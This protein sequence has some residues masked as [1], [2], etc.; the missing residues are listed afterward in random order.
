MAIKE[1]YCLLWK[2]RGDLGQRLTIEMIVGF[3]LSLEG[4]PVVILDSVVRQLDPRR[5][6]SSPR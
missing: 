4:V 5:A 2:L 1:V 3:P 6:L